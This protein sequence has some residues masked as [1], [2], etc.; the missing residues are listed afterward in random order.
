[1]Q[2][3]CLIYYIILYDDVICYESVVLFIELPNISVFMVG[4]Y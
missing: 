4:L 2:V 3:D 1:L